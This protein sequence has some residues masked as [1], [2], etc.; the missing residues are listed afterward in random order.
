MPSE[1]FLSINT[2]RTKKKQ[3]HRISIKINYRISSTLLIGQKKPC[4]YLW[5]FISRRFIAASSLKITV[6][7]NNWTIMDSKF[8]MAVNTMLH[9]SEK[10]HDPFDHL[11]SHDLPW[12]YFTHHHLSSTLNLAAEERSYHQPVG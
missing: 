12:Y 10:K 3:L 11:R 4:N 2:R 6:Y 8:Y 1:V 9:N 5:D 7:S